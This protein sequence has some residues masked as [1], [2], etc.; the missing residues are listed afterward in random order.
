MWLRANLHLLEL[1]REKHVE[2]LVSWQTSCVSSMGETFLFYEFIFII[3]SLLDSTMNQATAASYD[4][5][6]R[7]AESL[8]IQ[9]CGGSVC[10]YNENSTS[11]SVGRIKVA[12]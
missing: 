9:I 3:H 1:S 8:V 4:I 5:S 2:V 11:L 12:L 7:G 6:G 10:L